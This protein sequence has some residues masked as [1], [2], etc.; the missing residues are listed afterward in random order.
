MKI[1]LKLF[2][3]S[4]TVIVLNFNFSYAKTFPNSEGGV[5]ITV[6]DAWKDSVKNNV[7]QIESPDGYV[8]LFFDVLKDENFEDALKNTENNITS[9]LGELV[10]EKTAKIILNGMNT[11]I[12]DYKTKDGLVKVSVMLIFTP[13][14]KYMLC[15]YIGTE[16][17]D[18]KYEKELTEIAGSIKPITK[19]K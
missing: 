9:V 13:A 18:K 19:E 10:I 6:P 14:R 4:L 16:E 8:T 3:M 15:Y 17:A 12:E 1:F 5:E 2:M 11:F 7:L